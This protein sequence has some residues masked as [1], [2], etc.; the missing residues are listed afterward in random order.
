[1][2]HK[3]AI[4]RN[5]GAY[6]IHHKTWYNRFIVG[7]YQNPIISLLF[8]ILWHGVVKMIHFGRILIG[9]AEN[10]CGLVG[11]LYPVGIEWEAL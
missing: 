9:M 5:N 4:K 8:H 1:M 2:Y 6:M 7:Y 10:A 11:F 3:S